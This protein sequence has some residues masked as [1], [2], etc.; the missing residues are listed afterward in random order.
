MNIAITDNQFS[1]FYIRQKR[2]MLDIQL[3]KEIN[4]E[5]SLTPVPLAPA[6]VSGVINLRGTIVTVIDVGYCL[7]LGKSEVTEDTHCLITKAKEDLPDLGIS[8]ED[9][10][11]YLK[12]SI[13]LLVDNVG[14]ILSVTESQIESTPPNLQESHQ[15]FIKNVIK[16]EN[17]IIAYLDLIKILKSQNQQEPGH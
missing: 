14:D 5:F 10:E 16:L 7:G 17:E 8:D 11:E 9:S 6:H 3:I 4:S 1:T 2:F 15:D 12:D 13:G